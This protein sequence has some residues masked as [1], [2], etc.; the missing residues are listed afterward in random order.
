MLLTVTPDAVLA[1]QGTIIVM[2][3][4]TEDGNVQVFGADRRQ[5]EVLIDAALADGEAVAQ[6]EDYLLLGRPR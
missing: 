5:A 1:D 3:G 6:V 4:L 2:T